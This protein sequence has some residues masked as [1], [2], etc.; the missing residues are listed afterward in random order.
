MRRRSVFSPVRERT[1][2]QRDETPPQDRKLLAYSYIAVYKAA[3]PPDEST[4]LFA[5]S[6]FLADTASG[7]LSRCDVHLFALSI[8]KQYGSWLI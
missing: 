5:P 3:L 4:K 7:L 1:L 8:Q 2:N 6:P